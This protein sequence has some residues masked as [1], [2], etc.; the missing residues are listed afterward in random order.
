MPFEDLSYDQFINKW[1]FAHSLIDGIAGYLYG[2]I[3]LILIFVAINISAQYSAFAVYLSFFLPIL[4]F[5]LMLSRNRIIKF[6]FEKRTNHNSYAISRFLKFSPFFVSLAFAYLFAI[7]SQR[8]LLSYESGAF[9]FVASVILYLSVY[10]IFT[11]IITKEGEI[12]VEFICFV[13]NIS[14]FD[15]TECLRFWLVLCPTLIF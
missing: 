15:L 5:P 6:M 2:T 8:K 7:L 1:S 9:F 14:D 13:S 12:H 3:G 10:Q 11:R 4:Y